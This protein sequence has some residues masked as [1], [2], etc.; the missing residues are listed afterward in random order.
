MYNWMTANAGSG[1]GK[2]LY[3]VYFNVENFGPQFGV[4]PS[5]M[6]APQTAA[7]Y[8]SLPWGNGGNVDS[9]GGTTGGGTTG[10]GTTGGGT[11]GGGTTGG[12]DVSQTNNLLA[13]KTFTSSV[14]DSTTET[15]HP[16]SY[17]TDANGGTRWISQPTSPVNL[18]ADL[19][20]SYT[21]SKVSIKWAGDTIKN[22]QIQ[23]SANNSAWTTVYSGATNNTSPQYVD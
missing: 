12:S 22:F 14:G 9:G 15:G 11:T 3:D 10:G 6:G 18:T 20:S 1:P 16:V 4:F 7:K 23:V 2:V 8:Q 17:V 5:A 13:G 19:G 21:L